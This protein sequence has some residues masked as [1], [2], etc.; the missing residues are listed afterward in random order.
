MATGIDA[1]TLQTVGRIGIANNVASLYGSQDE[2][3]KEEK[4]GE[5]ALPIHGMVRTSF[6]VQFLGISE[7][8]SGPGSCSEFLYTRSL[9]CTGPPQQLDNPLRPVVFFTAHVDQGS[10][11]GKTIPEAPCIVL[12]K[13]QANECSTSL[14]Y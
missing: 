6:A 13:A 2:E 7:W 9:L 12:G 3:T 14:R 11:I 1:T 10:H 5:P 8:K 4:Y